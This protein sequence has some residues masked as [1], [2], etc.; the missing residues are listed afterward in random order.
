MHS[1]FF[2]SLTLINL[3]LMST[4][5]PNKTTNRMHGPEYY[6]AHGLQ[7]MTRSKKR[8][9][10]KIH[11]HDP[12]ASSP[13]PPYVFMEKSFLSF[14][15]SHLIWK[16]PKKIGVLCTYQNHSLDQTT[17]GSRSRAAVRAT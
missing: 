14:S 11:L 9:K 13:S 10:S 2:Y 12:P 17:T 3:K 15:A 6:W 5:K 7:Q 16:F 4:C 8:C 1:G